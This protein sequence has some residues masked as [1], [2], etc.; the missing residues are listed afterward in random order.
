VKKGEKSEKSKITYLVSHLELPILP[1]PLE[2][3]PLMQE[4]M[5]MPIIGLLEKER[6]KGEKSEKK[7][8]YIPCRLSRA[9]HAPSTPCVFT[10][11]ARGGENANYWSIREKMVKKGEKSKEKR[12]YIPWRLS[13]ASHSPST[14]SISTCD[15]GGGG[16]SNYWSIR[17]IKV[18][19][20]EKSKMKMKIHTL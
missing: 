14:H 9:P 19:K 8:N 16:N 13:R 15:A 3:P 18:K 10:C 5:G 4:V 17:E 1:V 11:D 20:G 7:R 2:S 6:W 12:N